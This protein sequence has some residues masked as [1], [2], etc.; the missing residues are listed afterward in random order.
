[1][2]QGV[3]LLYVLAFLP[4]HHFSF[5]GI[6]GYILGVYIRLLNYIVVVVFLFTRI[7]YFKVVVWA[8]RIIF[9]FAVYFP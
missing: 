6:A 5:L 9:F 3:V 1:M 4:F 7:P 8:D 2:M